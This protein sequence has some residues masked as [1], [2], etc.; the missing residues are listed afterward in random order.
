MVLLS[1]EK[2][3]LQAQKGALCTLGINRIIWLYLEFGAGVFNKE[4]SSN[5][6]IFC[7]FCILRRKSLVS[8]DTVCNI[9]LD[10]LNIDKKCTQHE[11]HLISYKCEHFQQN[12]LKI[13]PFS[14]TKSHIKIQISKLKNQ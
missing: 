12:I 5:I 3:V 1:E 13:N 10:S 11:I 7:L 9:L 2:L 8:T 6:L 14:S 4:T